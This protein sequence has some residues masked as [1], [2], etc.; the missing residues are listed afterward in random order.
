MKFLIKLNA[1]TGTLW[2]TAMIA[3]HRF[4]IFLLK[5]AELVLMVAFGSLLVVNIFA[6]PFLWKWHRFRAFLPFATYAFVV[7]L[8]ALGTRQVAKLVLAGTPCFP[9]SFLT[10]GTKSEMENIGLR[11]LG[12][13]LK[14]INIEPSA[15][16][17]Y[18]WRVTQSFKEIPTDPPEPPWIEMIAGHEKVEVP[19]DIIQQACAFGFRRIS[20][21]DAQSLVSFQHDR[22]GRRYDYI[23]TIKPLL[24]LYFRP[25]MFT[26]VD[27]GNWEDLLLIAKQGPHATEAQTRQIVFV[28]TIIY[29]LLEKELGL[30]LMEQLRS[31]SSATDIRDDQKRLVLAALN[32]Q[33]RANS[34]LVE[35]PRI[36]FSDRQLCL[37]DRRRIS[38]GVEVVRILMQLL[39]D[40]VL[41]LAEDKIH[42][43]LKQPLSKEERSEVEWLHVGIMESLYGNFLD[44]RKYHYKRQIDKHWYF[45]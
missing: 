28:P 42:L 35:H 33:C 45:N 11:L 26:E 6:I 34:R 37:G 16:D 19:P 20:I 25:V 1:I 7:A 38:E 15:F 22:A 44:K 43:K 14:E 30:Q 39:E 17:I 36:T 5:I 9:D 3:F 24:P 27:I 8:L 12:R 32:K 31:F 29:P 40:R 13:S 21:D 10:D 2:V 23:F 4:E 18:L 41:I